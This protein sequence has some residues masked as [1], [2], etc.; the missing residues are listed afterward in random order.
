M[1]Q[2]RQ[3]RREAGR[4]ILAHGEVTGHA[5]EVLTADT[6][7]PPDLAT[8]QYFEEPDGT[9]YLLLLKPCILTHQEHGRISLDPAA[10]A[11]VRQ[12]D[13]LL[14]PVGPG[15]WRVMRQR[16]WEGPDAWRQVAD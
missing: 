9:R 8:A 15:T 6:T 10:P 1:T 7:L 2:T 4:I 5:H 3:D 11:Q 13:V 14:M 12:G 16:E